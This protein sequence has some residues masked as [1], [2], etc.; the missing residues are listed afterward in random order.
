MAAALGLARRGLGNVAPNPAVGCV[1]V[2]AGAVV[3]RGWTQPGGRPHAETEALGRAGASARGATAYV[4]L[5]PC[6]HWGKTPPCSMALIEAG[7]ARAVVAIED[8]DPRVAGGGI[9]RLRAAGIAVDVGPMAA[10]AAA[11]N[12][13]FLSCV[14]K[15]RPLVALKAATGIDARIAT[16]SGESRWITGE[17]AR[18]RA[19]LLRSEYDAVMVG[20]HTAIVDDPE[21]T[22]RLPGLDARQPVRIVTDGRLRLPLTH[23]LVAGAK[24]NPTW[25]ITL[26]DGGPRADAFRAQGVELIIVPANRD[27]RPDMVAALK[28]LAGRGLTRILVEGGGL[29]AASLLA[30]RLVDRLLWFRAPRLMGGDGVPAVAGFGVDRLAE[31]AAFVRVSTIALGDDL[32][33]TYAVRG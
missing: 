19:H 26:A 9:K 3:G 11:V 13:G 4:S 25:I 30:G 17:A 22:C 12:A 6:D 29:L 33:E 16:R 21:L 18:Q 27:G 5:E 31:S 24:T 8:P 15:G 2:R 28:A 20:A 23:K 32:L 14:V 7:I 10:E 1:L